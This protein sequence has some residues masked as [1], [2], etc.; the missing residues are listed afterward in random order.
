MNLLKKIFFI[1]FIKGLSLTFKYNVSRTITMRYPDEEKW[2]PYQRFRGLHTLNR[3]SQG[4][5]LCVACELCAKVCP[6]QCITVIPMED[7]GTD[8]KSVPRGISDRIAKVYE[9]NLVRCLFCGFCEDA[10]PTTAIRMGRDYEL[11]CFTL[12]CAIAD[13]KKLLTPRDIP[14]EFEGGFVVKAKFIRN[15]EGI[16][17]KPDLSK[18][19]RWW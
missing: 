1:D 4:R 15:D 2:L 17:V 18:K 9:I 19:K 3:D 12:D 16:K 6:T 8:L 10:C 7:V 13:K 14:A 5:E 11:A